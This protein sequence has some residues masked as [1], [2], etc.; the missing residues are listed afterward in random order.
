MTFESDLFVSSQ[1][2]AHGTKGPKRLAMAKQARTRIY[3]ND[4]IDGMPELVQEWYHAVAWRY[5]TFKLHYIIDWLWNEP[6]LGSSLLVLA[7][8]SVVLRNA[9]SKKHPV[10]RGRHAHGSWKHGMGQRMSEERRFGR[11]REFV[12]VDW[13]CLTRLKFLKVY[14]QPKYSLNPFEYGWIMLNQFSKD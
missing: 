10:I 3:G 12:L 5:A 6:F 7:A 9:F 1:V 13:A 14:G 4:A 11:C 2:T 8:F